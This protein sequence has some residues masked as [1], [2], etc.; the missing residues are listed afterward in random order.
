MGENSETT[1]EP[2]ISMRRVDSLNLEA[3]KVSMPNHH[4]SNVRLYSNPK[5]LILFNCH[6]DWIF[7][8]SF[9]VELEDNDQF[10]IPEH[11]DSV[12]GHR[13]ISALC[14]LKHFS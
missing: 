12:W 11:R 2:R 4:G 1:D 6:K 7:L 10:S 14:I 8:F 9:S 5:S 13:D 3:G